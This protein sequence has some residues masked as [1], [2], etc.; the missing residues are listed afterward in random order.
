FRDG[1]REGAGSYTFAN[2]D[3]LNTTFRRGRAAGSGTY[4]FKDGRVFRGEFSNTTRELTGQGL[5]L[6]KSGSRFCILRDQTLAC[7]NATDQSAKTPGEKRTSHLLILFASESCQIV[8]GDRT[9]VGGPGV[10]LYAGDRIEAG[11]EAVELQ[12]RGGIAI[13]L[14]PYSILEIPPGTNDRGGILYLRKGG[15]AVDYQGDPER[16]PFRINAKSTNF[17]VQGTTFMVEIDDVKGTAKV[18]VFE[19]TVSVSPSLPAL[20]KLDVS[21]SPTAVG[22]EGDA[23]SRAGDSEEEKRALS[24]QELQ[25][26]ADAILK[27][28]MQVSAN[29]EGELSKPALEKAQKLNAT[30]E[31]TIEERKNAPGEAEENA[32]TPA[33]RQLTVSAQELEQ[34]EAAAP[35]SFQATPQEQ[36][37]LKLLIT[38]DAATFEQAVQNRAGSGES[39]QDPRESVREAYDQKLDTRAT[40]L[41]KE[42]AADQNIR[43]Q[44]DLIERYKFLEVI[45][46]RDGKQKAGSVAAQ[47]GNILIMH[48]PDGVF[49]L[50]RED[51]KQIDFYDVVQDEAAGS[52]TDA[53]PNTQ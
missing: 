31:Q 25:K 2:G 18:R 3:V 42:L 19:G 51:V 24:D 41:Q 53:A 36:A 48:A 26:V 11:N 12:G 30:I 13:R 32:S 50:N 8:R 20:E 33:A 37:E 1:L 47:A 27:Q 6:E 46:F 28:T 35:E 16:I 40:A 4:V 21:Q 17:D 7:N 5:L 38:I 14:R 29:Q 39:G 34:N 43:T 49:R 15:V 44:A 10:P 23:N 22:S 9:L 45:T 52:A